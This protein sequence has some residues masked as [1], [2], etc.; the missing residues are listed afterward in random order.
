MAFQIIPFTFLGTFQIALF[1]GKE[2]QRK[3]IAAAHSP[4]PLMEL[5]RKTDP[6]LLQVC[7]LFFNG[8]EKIGFFY[9]HKDVFGTQGEQ[10]TGEGT[11]R[12]QNQPDIF[13]SQQFLNHLIIGLPFFHA[14]HTLQ[15]VNNDRMLHALLPDRDL[16]GFRLC[17]TVV[18][19]SLHI[20]IMDNQ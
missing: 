18:N 12:N 11:A 20:Q 10:P 17:R 4:C 8:K 6:V 5:V 14:C 1:H 2:K 7:T 13:P 9:F 15:V 3:R 19:A 16:T